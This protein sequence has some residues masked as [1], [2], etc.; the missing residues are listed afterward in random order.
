M[1]VSKK[2]TPNSRPRRMISR[3]CSSSTVQL[4]W[5]R[6]A[7]PKP[8]HP[9]QMRDTVKF[10]FPSF[11]YS[12]FMPPRFILDFPPATGDGYVTAAQRFFQS[13]RCYVVNPSQPGEPPGIGIVWDFYDLHIFLTISPEEQLRRIRQRERR[14]SFGGF[15]KQVDSARRKVF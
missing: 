11:V 4:C 6:A 1:A 9:M 14:K 10:E 12:I 7:S 3:E 5:P 8:I 2:L 13:L 15:S